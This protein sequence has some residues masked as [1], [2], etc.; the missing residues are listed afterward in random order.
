MTT[1][2]AREILYNEYEGSKDFMTPH[3]IKVGKIDRT[4]AFELSWGEGLYS[5]RKMYG[6]SVVEVTST[7]P[8]ETR[9]NF[10]LSMSFS[11]RTDADNHVKHL[12]DTAPV[13]HCN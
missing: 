1:Y 7:D 11:S 13:M 12:K 10:E 3:V 5:D 4:L 8:L 9:R 6:V 2:T